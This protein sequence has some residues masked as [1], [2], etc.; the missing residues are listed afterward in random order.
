MPLFLR[1]DPVLEDDYV[2]SNGNSI[3]LFLRRTLVR[4]SRYAAMRDSVR[5]SKNKDGLLEHCHPEVRG[6][7]TPQVYR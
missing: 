5:Y 3:K 7:Y 2:V 6:V 4:L 1:G